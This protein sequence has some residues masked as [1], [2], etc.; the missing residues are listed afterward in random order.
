MC[1]EQETELSTIK[2]DN[3][4]YPY[5]SVSPVLTGNGN[6]FDKI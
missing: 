3:V 4:N 5:S 2:L 1:N 6:P